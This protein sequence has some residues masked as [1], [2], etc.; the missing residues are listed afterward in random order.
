MFWQE[1]NA[2]SINSGPQLRDHYSFV[3]KS[4]VWLYGGVRIGLQR[5]VSEH[6]YHFDIENTKWKSSRTTP[7]NGE[8][9]RP[10]KPSVPSNT[11][12]IFHHG[13]ER[14]YAFGGQVQYEL[15]HLGLRGAYLDMNTCL[16]HGIGYPDGVA[17]IKAVCIWNDKVHAID[18]IAEMYILNENVKTTISKFC[19]RFFNLE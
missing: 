9:I 1:W 14:L 7:F 18:S 2:G 6:M 5:N 8:W 3:W 17:D 4:S 10:D 12:A 13:Q 16:W 11:V 19:L 15:G